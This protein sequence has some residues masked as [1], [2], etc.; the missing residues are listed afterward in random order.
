MDSVKFGCHCD[1]FDDQEPDECV[2]DL[3]CSDDCH[4]TKSGKVTSKEQCSEWKPI[5]I[6]K[7]SQ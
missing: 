5:T 4:Y 1:I 2:L 6:K 3:G 7:V